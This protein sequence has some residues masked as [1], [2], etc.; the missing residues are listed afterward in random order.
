[1]AVLNAMKFKLQRLMFGGFFIRG[2]PYTM[3][4]ISYAIKFWSKGEHQAM[5]MRHEGFLGAM[6]AFLLSDT[7]V[8][9]A[10][11]RAVSEAKGSWCDTHAHIHTT[12]SSR[13]ARCLLASLFAL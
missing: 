9:K 5:F 6:G 7:A 12:Q 1:M 11:T 2:H 4:T 8:S 3:E 10:L 13:F